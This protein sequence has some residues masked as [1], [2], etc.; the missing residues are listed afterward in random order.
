MDICSIW[1]HKMHCKET[2]PHWK[3]SRLLCVRL[4]CM[5]YSSRPRTSF[6]SEC[7]WIHID[8]SL[9]LVF[10][11]CL[12]LFL[13]NTSS[14]HYAH[15]HFFHSPSHFWHLLSLQCRHSPKSIE[16]PLR[17]C[18]SSLHPEFKV[19]AEPCLLLAFKAYPIW[20]QESK[21][22]KHDG[23]VSGVIMSHKS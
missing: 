23:R 17:S 6:I 14:T 16:R 21:K 11:H 8:F 9:L 22:H 20:L 15:K 5:N 7:L 1:N 10:A 4:C 12:A 19:R 13:Y 3:V 2:V 18:A